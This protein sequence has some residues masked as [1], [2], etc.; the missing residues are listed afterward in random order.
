M[1]SFHGMWSFAGFTGALMGLGML[2][3]KLSTYHHFL[4]VGAIVILMMGFNY[5]YLIKAKEIPKTEKKN[6][7][8]NQIAP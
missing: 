8:Q 2:A 4:L 5:K 3:L 6:H 1:S 7:F